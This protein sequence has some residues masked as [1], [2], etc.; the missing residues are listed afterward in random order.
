MDSSFYIRMAL[1]SANSESK[2]SDIARTLKS[3]KWDK[4]VINM[5]KMQML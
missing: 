3:I 1:K 4:Y 2:C 5:T